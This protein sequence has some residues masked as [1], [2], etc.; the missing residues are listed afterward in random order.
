MGLLPH[1][2][3]AHFSCKKNTQKNAI[4]RVQDPRA[5]RPYIFSDKRK[6]TNYE[7]FSKKKKLKFQQL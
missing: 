6:H 2:F 4:R 1:L 3:D 7:A 5:A